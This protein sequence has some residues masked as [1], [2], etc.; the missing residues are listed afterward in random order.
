MR[1]LVHSS[2]TVL[3]VIRSANHVLDHCNQTPQG[4]AKRRRF[5]TKSYQSNRF[6]A[7]ICQGNQLD[8]TQ[9]TSELIS[10]PFCPPELPNASC[11]PWTAKC[12]GL[13]KS[14]SLEQSKSTCY[15]SPWVWRMRLSSTSSQNQAGSRL[16]LSNCQ[17]FHAKKM[18]GE[19]CETE[20][21]LWLRNW[22][23]RI[24]WATTA[25]T[26]AGLLLTTWLTIWYANLACWCAPWSNLRRKIVTVGPREHATKIGFM[27]LQKEK[28]YKP[29]K[30]K[31]AT[32]LAYEWNI[33]MISELSKI[34]SRMACLL[35]SL[36]QGLAWNKSCQWHV[37]ESSIEAFQQKRIRWLF[38]SSAPQSKS[39]WV[40]CWIM[41]L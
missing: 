38:S 7:H 41:K 28:S 24:P 3:C 35:Q 21:S 1:I 20:K 25:T 22:E 33:E 17:W 27:Q 16:H 9:S 12:P 39:P 11:S 5:A 19:T 6:V 10:C 34:T 18:R 26:K 37:I 32:S 8:A 15:I 30:M 4:K 23:P 14:R 29:T 31:L 2:K 13:T 36:P 40:H